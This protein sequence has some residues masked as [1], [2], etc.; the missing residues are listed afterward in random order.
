MNW[1]NR[2][3]CGYFNSVNNLLACHFHNLYGI[4]IQIIWDRAIR[5]GSGI[6]SNMLLQ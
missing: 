2:A 6:Y 1:N 3:I 5:G 4:K